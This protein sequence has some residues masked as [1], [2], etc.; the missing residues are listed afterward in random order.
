MPSV[1]DN[2]TGK[3][4]SNYLMKKMSTL[5]NNFSFLKGKNK[6]LLLN[7]N[8][9]DKYQISEEGK[10]EKKEMKDKIIEFRKF[11][12]KNYAANVINKIMGKYNEEERKNYFNKRKIGTIYISNKNNLIN[13]INKQTEFFKLRSTGYT[14]EIKSIHSFS[15]KDINDLYTEL[16][17]VKEDFISK[18]DKEPKD[19]E[20]ENFWI[21]SYEKLKKNIFEKHTENIIKEKKKLL[22]YIVY[23]N[24]KGR[25]AFLNDILK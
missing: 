19:K 15:E 24:I 20:K 1:K 22:E 23:Q 14:S 13:N 6:I 17:Q 8:N 7:E 5:T 18:I 10:N 21:K 4:E 9:N 11:L 12:D 2:N 16:C 3:I 25:K